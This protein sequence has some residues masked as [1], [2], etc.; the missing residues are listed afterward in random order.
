M[1]DLKLLY[2]STDFCLT[3]NYYVDTNDDKKIQ[4]VLIKLTCH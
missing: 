1:K 4:Q 3:V 2:N